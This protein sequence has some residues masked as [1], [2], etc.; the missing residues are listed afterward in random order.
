MN[1]TETPG[2]GK[3][4]YSLFRR[5]LD[6]R[7]PELICV[8]GSCGGGHGTGLGGGGRS[9]RRQQGLVVNRAG[10][11]CKKRNIFYNF[12]ICSPQP[13]AGVL[14]AHYSQLTPL[15]EVAVQARQST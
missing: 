1:R 10:R 14:D 13:V 3:M 12:P 2:G 6:A 11:H 5:G 15:S 4:Y 8:G 7:L 9:C